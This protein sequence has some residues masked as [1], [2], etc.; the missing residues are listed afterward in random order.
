MIT[1]MAL[2]T[3]RDGVSRDELIDYYENH[4]VPLVLSRAPAPAYY[5]RNYLP[6]AADRRDDAGFDVLTHMQFADQATY[7]QWLEL[8]LA[9]DSG[10]AEDEA[11]FL[12]R[13]RTRS[14]T[15]DEH[16]SAAGKQEKTPL[17][18]DNPGGLDRV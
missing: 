6:A 15:V 11:R 13:A 16:R 10:V 1:V 3:A 12:D 7:R 14:W 5:A 4:H 2:L 8:V 18:T 17:T 9:A